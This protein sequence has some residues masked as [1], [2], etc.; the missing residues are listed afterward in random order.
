MSSAAATDSVII[1]GYLSG[2]ST[3][4][5]AASIGRTFRHVRYRARVLGI[6]HSSKTKSVSERF[7]SFVNP[8]PN[9]GCFLWSG[10]MNGKGRPIMNIGGRR[11]LASHVAMELDGH[12]LPPGMSALHKCDVPACV[13]PAHIFFG[14][15]LE[16][17]RDCRAKGRLFAMSAERRLRPVADGECIN[18]H[19]LSGANLYVAPNGAKHCRVCRAANG[20][21]LRKRRRQSA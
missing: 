14:K 15:Q 13:N 4:E 3:E 10:A 11:T 21:E 17:V 19:S 16:N 8:E 20:R 7:S 18:G 5:I 12:P 6:I 9:S 1:A 2:T